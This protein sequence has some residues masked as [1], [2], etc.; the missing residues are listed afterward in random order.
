LHA[1]DG[2]HE[3]A[4]VRRQLVVLPLGCAI[5]AIGE[6][7][8]QLLRLPAE[9]KDNVVDHVAVLLARGQADHARAETLVHVIVE[10]GP[11]ERALAVVDLQIAASQLELIRD[12]L[13]QPPRGA[14][15]KR[16][17][18]K[19]ALF[20]IEPAR[21]DDA[22][23][24]LRHRDLDVRIGLVVAKENVVARLVGLDEIVLEED[25]L[26]LVVGRDEVD[27]FDFF[28]QRG[29]ERIAITFADDV[30]S[31]A[32]AQV[33][34]L[35]DVDHL[36]LGVFVHVNAGSVGKLLDASFEALETVGH[37]IE[38]QQLR[39]EDYFARCTAR[40]AAS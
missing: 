28:N 40:Q 11:R 31:D 5:H 14:G 25:R 39:F 2:A 3:I 22:R 24:I 27:R 20:S 19:I 13:Q 32:V 6:S 1:L 37:Q 10:T 21:E 12:E 18:E 23:K 26:Q 16:T 34:R 15:K 38:L 30:G 33:P 29:A 7:F 9:K 35:P 8:L 36:T 4:V 17:I